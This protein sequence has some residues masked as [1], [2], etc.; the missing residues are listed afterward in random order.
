LPPIK[1][2]HP[3]IHPSLYYLPRVPTHQTSSFHPLSHPPIRFIIYPSATLV[4][5]SI[6]SLTHPPI[7]P[8]ASLLSYNSTCLSRNYSLACP[9]LSLLLDLSSYPPIHPP[10]YSFIHHTPTNEYSLGLKNFHVWQ[11]RTHCLNL[12]SRLAGAS[13]PAGENCPLGSP[14]LCPGPHLCRRPAIFRDLS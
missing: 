11:K 1:S 6:Q 3:S 2:A 13:N 14:S 4:H 8:F 5:P 9:F 10:I 12:P 7:R